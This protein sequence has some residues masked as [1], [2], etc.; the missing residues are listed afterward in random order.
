[1]EQI[2]KLEKTD[3]ITA[4]R[5]RVDFAFPPMPAV[6]GQAPADKPAKRRLLVVVPRGN[7]TLQSLVNMKLLARLAEARAIELA[8]VSGHPTVRD[9]AKEAGVK[10]Y[11]SLQV[12]KW[13]G[14]VTSTAPVASPDATLPPVTAADEAGLEIEQ[15]AEQ[16]KG[17]SA[18]QGTAK[19]RVKKKKY[20][21]VYGRGRIG[22][23]QQLGALLA[24]VILAFALV[25]GAIAL[26]PEATITLTPVARS[27]ETELIVRADPEA[28]S[29]DYQTLT[30]PARTAQVELALA[31]EI[32]TVETELAPSGHASG[33]VT[34]IN[35]TPNEQVIPISTTLSTSVGEQ[36]KFAIVET[37]TI[38]A[39]VDTTTSTVAVAVEPGPKG[40]VKAG[41]LNRFDEPSY[42]LLARVVNERPFE[43]GIVEPAKIVVQADKERLQAYLRQ[44]IQQEGL[45]QLEESLA[46]QEFVPPES[47][48]VIVLD[49]SYKEFSGDFSDIFGGEMQAVVRGTVVGG[50]NANRLALAALEAQVPPGYEL[51]V[52]GLHFGAGEVLDVRDRVVTFRVFADGKAVPVIDPHQIADDVA[53]LSIGEAQAQ[54]NEQYHLAAVPGVELKPDWLV[55]WVGRLPF[56]PLRI[57]VI[58]NQ[59]VTLTADGG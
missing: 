20:R 35:R 8:I 30:F 25:A 49:V 13:A 43:G 19:E 15:P 53:W 41:Q 31:G 14:W 12:A 34:F 45:R 56:V 52:E 50:Y 55:E 6:S 4:I 18:K 5:S 23:L 37:T 32:E 58:I 29:L 7:K 42:A 40:N 44:K 28:D 57:N 26:L 54:L 24:L 47:L 36:I 16:S 38:P 2:L 46:A 33:T 51:D 21:V 3:D 39:G 22:Y 48:Q 59:A 9:Y 11:G 1:M 17:K 10:A 27:V